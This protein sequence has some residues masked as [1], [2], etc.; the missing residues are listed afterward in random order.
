M[1]SSSYSKR[2]DKRGRKEQTGMDNAR[3]VNRA[4]DNSQRDREAKVETPH[5]LEEDSV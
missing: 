1:H 3:I 4:K 5:E 2:M